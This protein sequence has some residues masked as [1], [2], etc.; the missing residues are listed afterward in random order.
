MTETPS[1]MRSLGDLAIGD[2]AVIIGY[3]DSAPARRLLEMGFLPG[4]AV[5]AIRRAPLGDPTEFVV[6]G[7]RVSMRRADASEI[8]V[9]DES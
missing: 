5:K 2:A 1:S 3:T 4:N 9:M 8:I 7:C 6:V